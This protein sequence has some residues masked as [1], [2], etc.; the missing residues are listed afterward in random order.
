MTNKEK[1]VLEIIKKHPTIEQSEIARLLNIKRSTVA[2]HI[3]NLIKRGYIKGKGYIINDDQYIVGIGSC[4]V[5]VYGKAL[6][7][8]KKQYDHPARINSSIGGVMYNIIANYT[9]LSGKGKLITAYSD[10]IYGEAI[11]KEALFKNI[12][13]SESLFIENK[14]SGMFMQIMDDNNDMHLAICDMEI[15]H[16][17]DVDFI[18]GKKHI[19]VNSECV[20]VDP[21]LNDDVI[22]RIIDICKNKVDIYVDPISDNYA[23][24]MKKYLHEIFLIKPNITELEILAN[25]KISDDDS[26]YKACEKLLEKGVKKV[27][28][29]LSENGILYM[30]KDISI[31]RK[32]K[33]E[34]RMVNASGAG[35]ALMASLIY[36]HV[37]GFELDKI[38]DYSLA[39]G[40]AAIR[41][42]NTINDKMSI[43]LLENILKEKK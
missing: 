3:S 31:K 42:Q 34:K 23:R 15:L 8:I 36:G 27:V 19:L 25:Q 13:I 24:K 18:D 7:P 6:I 40:I 32:L 20:I 1:Q 37:H 12:D 14:S 26:L 28:V 9:L 4:N 33:E 10:D 43:D 5:D 35:D 41:S 30:D 21:S 38:V 29:S 17:I 22:Q 16:S 2:V 39:A 11:V